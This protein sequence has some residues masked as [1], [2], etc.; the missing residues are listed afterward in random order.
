MSQF[1]PHSPEMASSFGKL[2]IRQ[3]LINYSITIGF[4]DF[5]DWH[6]DTIEVQ[7][8]PTIIHFVEPDGE[9][10]GLKVFSARRIEG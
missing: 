2:K 6:L 8:S 9:L 4:K 7:I 3:D 10:V 1:I 5:T